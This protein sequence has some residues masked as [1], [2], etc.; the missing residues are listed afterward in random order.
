MT[1]N[2]LEAEKAAIECTLKA[3][4][5]LAKAASITSEEDQKFFVQS[6]AKSLEGCDFLGCDV[7]ESTCQSVFEDSASLQEAS[8]RS[9]SEPLAVIWS[10]LHGYR[11]D[12]ISEDD[13][14]WNSICNAMDDLTV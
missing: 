1:L 14:E 4:K 9:Q 8:P 7:T 11:E 3:V 13:E 5:L 12:C 10:A 2:A 6:L